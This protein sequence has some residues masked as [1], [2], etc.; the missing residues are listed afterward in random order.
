VNGE[1][2]VHDVFAIGG[3]RRTH[4]GQPKEDDR[5]EQPRDDEGQVAFAEFGASLGALQQ[6]VERLA[7]VLDESCPQRVHGRGFGV[8]HGRLHRRSES[9]A[10]PASWDGG[11]P[12]PSPRS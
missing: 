5:A 2:V 3:G 12:I 8:G 4:A 6:L 10:Q 1:E 9:H 7:V 11:G